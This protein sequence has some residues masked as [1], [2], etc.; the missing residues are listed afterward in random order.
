MALVSNAPSK[1][2]QVRNGSSRKIPLDRDKEDDH[3]SGEK[4]ADQVQS[5]DEDQTPDERNGSR[6]LGS[7]LPKSKVMPSL[8]IRSEGLAS[9]IEYMNDHT[10]IA[11]FIGFGPMEKDLI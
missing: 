11:K 10:L 4:Q 8:I 5:I 2:G 3:R 9:H 7:C 1:A 6:Q